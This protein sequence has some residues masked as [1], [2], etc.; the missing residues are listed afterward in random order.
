MWGNEEAAVVR[1]LLP[2]DIAN[3]VRLVGES[4]SDVIIAVEEFEF[5]EAAT[6]G[7]EAAANRILEQLPATMQ[8]ISASVPDFFA[9][10][11]AQAADAPEDAEYVRNTWPIAVQ[12]D[13]LSEI[14]RLTFVDETGF[15][16]FVGNVAAL[17]QSGNALTRSASET[18]A[19]RIKA[20]PQ[21]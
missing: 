17:L 21:S 19:S 13:A 2:S 15:R 3:I 14:V 8:K 16:K 12:V 11:I 5:G 20:G 4:I 7:A 10:V 18:T 1:G 9:V 6:K